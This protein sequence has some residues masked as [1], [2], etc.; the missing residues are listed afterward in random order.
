MRGIEQNTLTGLGVTILGD[1]HAI[2]NHAKS[3]SP[4]ATATPPAAAPTPAVKAKAR[5]ANLPTI[6]AEMTQPQFRKVLIDWKV[7]KNIAFIPA[8]QISSHIYNTC[9]AEVQSTLVNIAP[10]FLDLE[11]TVLLKQI[12]SIVTKAANPAVH[13]TTFTTIVQGEGRCIQEF[14]T[15]LRTA[16]V[17]CSFE[18]P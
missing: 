8:D 2:I 11:E 12:E 16:A 17:E 9:S 1:Q 6:E 18:C 4:T 3:L 10:N 14:E 7:Y 13:R 5:P 15:S